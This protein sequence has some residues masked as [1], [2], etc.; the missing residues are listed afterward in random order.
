MKTKVKISLLCAIYIIN[1]LKAQDLSLK[2]DSLGTKTFYLDEITLIETQIPIK[3]KESGRSIIKIDSTDLKKF[4]GRNISE[5]LSTKTGIITLGNAS[6]TGQNIRYAIRGSNNNQVLILIDGVRISDPSRI[7][8]DFDIN[9][10]NINQ[11]ESIEVLKG[12]SSSLYGS[13]ASAGVINITTKKSGEKESFSIDLFTGTENDNKRKLDDLTYFSTNLGFNKD[14]TFL[15]LG[16]NFSTLNTNGMSAVSTGSEIDNFFKYNFNL[17]LSNQDGPIKWFVILNKSQIKNG[18]DN[19]FPIEDANFIGL[20]FLESF[21]SRF[22]YQYSKGEISLTTGYQNTSREYRDNY[23]LTFNSM[24]KSVEIL[25]KFK[26]SDRIYS[27]QGILYQDSGYDGVPN[28]SQ[29]GL[30]SNLVYLSGKNLNFSLG[31]RINNHQTYGNFFT[32]SLNPSYNIEIK[33]LENVKM[34]AT[35]NS[36]FIAPSLYQLYDPYSGNKD[37]MPEQSIS[38]EIGV[39]IF[40]KKRNLSI[41]FFER[42]ENPKIIYEYDFSTFTGGYINSSSDLTFRGVEIDYSKIFF[43][44]IDFN[45]NY[46][47][48]ELKKGTLQ[49]LPKHSFNESITYNLKK[50]RQL[51]FIYRY[52]GKREALGI[53]EILDSYGLMDLRYSFSKNKINFNFWINNIFNK[54]YVE[55]LNYTNKGRNLR[56]GINYEF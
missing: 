15:K 37:L 45:F 55:I 17:N 51:S 4:G 47:F 3:R 12:A 6:I 1:N 22:N 33:E 52:R 28:V 16:L 18:Y 31:G 46:A 13:S 27:V 39:E 14:L 56:F 34:F 48:N 35:L 9:F 11:I 24:N 26:I 49:R 38:K 30:Y 2:K 8:N 40:K 43:K 53:K 54:E 44:K 23:P 36:A 50:N 7:D 5:L 21:S 20:S 10:L 29:V 42:E 32:Y 25:N 19:S 41:V